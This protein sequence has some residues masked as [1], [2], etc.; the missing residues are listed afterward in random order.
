MKIQLMITAN[1]MQGG[2]NGIKTNVTH[3]EEKGEAQMDVMCG[4]MH[5]VIFKQM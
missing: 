5:I 4:E 2:V 3:S 1:M